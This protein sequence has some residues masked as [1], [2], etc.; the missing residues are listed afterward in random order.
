MVPRLT[1]R[2]SE[3]GQRRR[4]S[5]EGR[6]SASNSSETADVLNGGMVQSGRQA[7]ENGYRAGEQRG[8]STTTARDVTHTRENTGNGGSFG[9]RGASV[10]R[11][12]GD[13]IELPRATFGVGVLVFFPDAVRFGRYGQH[14]SAY[15][16]RQA[17]ADDLER[18]A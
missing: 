17:E 12:S 2:R 4:H 15:L 14:A 10:A 18:T 11:R 6:A 1:Q 3:D 8:E 5:N 16:R 13:N 9:R 7:T